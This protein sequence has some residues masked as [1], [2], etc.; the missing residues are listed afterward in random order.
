M[1]K[2]LRVLFLSDLKINLASPLRTVAFYFSLLGAFL[3]MAFF[4][5]RSQGMNDEFLL[6]SLK[7]VFI[8]GVA[9]GSLLFLVAL[10][11]SVISASDY[12]KVK[13]FADK[14]SKGSF[15]CSPKLSFIA[16][17]D[18]VDIRE[19]LDRMQKSILIS[20]EL[21]KKRSKKC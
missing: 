10:F 14:I 18:L 7:R 13:E 6:T 1:K 8:Y 12:K 15:T 2:L 19:S 3:L 16:D 9:L 21:L 5:L 17:K 11:Y 4:T 20:R